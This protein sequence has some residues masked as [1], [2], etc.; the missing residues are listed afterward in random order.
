MAIFFTTKSDP[1]GRDHAINFDQV[2]Y[3]VDQEDTTAIYFVDGG[4]PLFV[5]TPLKILT[6]AAYEARIRSLVRK[7]SGRL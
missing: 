1:T 4:A 5:H 6:Q 3:M 2:R 7:G